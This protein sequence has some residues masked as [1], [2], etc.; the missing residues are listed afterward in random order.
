MMNQL[1]PLEVYSIVFN[2]LE[3][4][5]L[6]DDVFKGWLC[7]DEEKKEMLDLLV[8]HELSS[9][10]YKCTFNSAVLDP[11]DI[12]KISDKHLN[13]SVKL[14]CIRPNQFL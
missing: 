3:D 9:G 5:V 12:R 1:H 8:Q 4:R 13:D 7:L 6:E 10:S 14:P 2:M 11:I